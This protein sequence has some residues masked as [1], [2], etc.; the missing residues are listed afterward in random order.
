MPI[1]LIVGIGV[2]GFGVYSVL[3]YLQDWWPFRLKVERRTQQQEIPERK[4]SLGELMGEHFD[5]KIR[6]INPFT[7]S[8]FEITP[9]ESKGYPPGS[10]ILR[11]R[12]HWAK[13]VEKGLLPPD[14]KEQAE[15]EWGEWFAGYREDIRERALGLLAC[16]RALRE[17]QK[18]TDNW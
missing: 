7:D 8:P 2:I 1:D 11:Y 9:E 10:E 4:K 15:K 18:K 3:A 6:Y 12:A 13:L 14:W 16:R 17:W 5:E